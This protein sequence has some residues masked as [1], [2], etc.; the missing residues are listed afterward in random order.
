M[1]S[2]EGL[3]LREEGAP[4]LSDSPPPSSSSS[5]SS[6]NGQDGVGG[7][8]ALAAKVVFLTLSPPSSV[9]VVHISLA[10]IRDT[11][12]RSELECWLS[13]PHILGRRTFF[14]GGV[15][16]RMTFWQKQG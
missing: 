1:L 16:E 10:F 3:G 13:A 6:S 2:G 11:W 5:S 15:G 12:R 14:W 9:G 4:G 7:G 8:C